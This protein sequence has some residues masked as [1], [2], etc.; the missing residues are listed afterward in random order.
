[1]PPFR[2]HPRPHECGQQAGLPAPRDDVLMFQWRQMRSRIM[3]VAVAAL[4]TGIALADSSEYD[5]YGGWMKFSG[6]KTGFFHTQQIDGRWWLIT[7]E[8][9]AFFSKGVD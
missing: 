5:Q 3:I 2:W 1:M 9:H 6:A 8:G 7:P 4:L